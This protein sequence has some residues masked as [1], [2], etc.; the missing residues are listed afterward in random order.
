MLFRSYT[1]FYG[2]GDHATLAKIIRRLEC[3]WMLTY[4][5]VPEIEKLYAGLPMHRKS[6]MYSAQVKRRAN[7]LLVLAP[8]LKVPTSLSVVSRSHRADGP[9][10]VVRLTAA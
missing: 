3:P 10:Q 6:L 7:E 9:G 4:D 5:D 1:N 8:H 2:P